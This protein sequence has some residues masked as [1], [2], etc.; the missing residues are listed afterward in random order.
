MKNRN[1]GIVTIIDNKNI[2]NRLQNY[3]TQE[4]LKENLLTSKTIKNYG[5]LKKV[6]KLKLVL[7]SIIKENNR[8]KRLKRYINF[9]HF[10]KNIEFT[11][12]S[13]EEG[14]INKNKKVNKKF[15]TF[16]TGS[17]QVWNCNFGSFSS[18]YFLDF[19]EGEKRNAFSASF[20]ISSIP[21]NK[22]NY[23]KNWLNE[24]NKISVR[25]ERGKEIVEELTGRKDVEVLLDPTMLMKTQNWERVMKK[26][27][28]L[29]AYN[30]KKFILN[31]FLGSLSQ[32]RRNEIER[33]AKEND[34]KIINILDK[35]DPFYVCGPSEFL[36]LEKNA[37]LV[38]TDSFHSSVFAILF[39]TPFVVFDREDSATRMN[40]RLDTLIKTFG[41]NDRW[42]NER[43][44][45]NQLKADYSEV[46]KIL[47]MERKKARE[48]IKIALKEEI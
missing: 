4:F 10:N 3:A 19:A 24:M 36:Y 13:L 42:F 47:E 15:K 28:Q 46:N 39:N 12:Y 6:L 41:L 38:C 27:K 43:K 37:L 33:I 32:K 31:Y 30:D 35:N 34:C 9:K 7:R 40:S 18:I 20:G 5:S 21:E 16:I 23:Y 11:S 48:F 22:R 17:D 29:D 44:N 26:P 2:G 14:K 45:K 8:I 1:V 25:E